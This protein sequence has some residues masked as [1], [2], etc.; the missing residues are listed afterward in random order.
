MLAELCGFVNVNKPA[1]WSSRDAVNRIARLVRPAKAGHVGTLDPLA[2]GVLVVAVGRATRLIEY[3]QRSQKRYL[4]TFQLGCAS[5]TEDTEGNVIPL[6][7]PPRPTL[8]EIETKAQ[9]FLGEIR[10]RPPAY[11]ALK[12]NGR[13]AYE[14]ARGGQQV[15]LEPRP[16]RIDVL[17]VTAYHY[18]ELQLEIACGSGTYVRSLGRDLAEALGTGAVMSQLVRTAVGAFRQEDAV[19]I[20]DAAWSGMTLDTFQTLLAP[21]ALAVADLPVW[22]A[23]DEE[24]L[25]LWQGKRT[26][27]NARER[28]LAH[29]GACEFAIRDARGA[30]LGLA[31]PRGNAWKLVRSV[32]PGY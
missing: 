16:V 32:R 28:E 24:L 25:H 19:N 1:G 9:T 13:R 30:F 18:P 31:A 10:Q 15:E 8:A 12:V 14:L 29:S 7:T 26:P 17:R 5:D 11:S 20:E 2:T 3:V 6:D 4:G 21:A 23:S 22:Q 27:V